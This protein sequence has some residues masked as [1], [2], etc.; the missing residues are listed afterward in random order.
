MTRL[1]VHDHLLPDPGLWYLVRHRSS[2]VRVLLNAGILPLEWGSALVLG[3][4]RG[5]ENA[6]TIPASAT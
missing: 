4:P 1:E 5:S 6:A 2:L 3:H